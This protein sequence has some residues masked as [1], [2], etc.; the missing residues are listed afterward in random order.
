MN[1]C[2]HRDLWPFLLALQKDLQDLASPFPPEKIHREMLVINSMSSQLNLTHYFCLL[3]H[4][5]SFVSGETRQAIEPSIPLIFERNRQMGSY[6]WNNTAVSEWKYLIS[7]FSPLL[8]PLLLHR[9]LRL[10]QIDPTTTHTLSLDTA[11]YRGRGWL[12]KCCSKYS[13]PFP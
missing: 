5:M 7:A 11:D 8:Q 4:L 3:A 12:M 10:Y 13:H 1:T 6:F 9:G 2:D